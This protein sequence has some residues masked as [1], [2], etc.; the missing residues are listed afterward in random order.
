MHMLK[1]L[2]EQVTKMVDAQT[3]AQQNAGFGNNSRGWDS[4]DKFKN[5]KT[6]AGEQKDWE[7]FS[8]K[9]RSQLAAGS[10]KMVESKAWKR[11]IGH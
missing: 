3:Y 8:L 4:P 1:Y 10:V 6:F 2:G 11:R 7:E 5:I 9:L